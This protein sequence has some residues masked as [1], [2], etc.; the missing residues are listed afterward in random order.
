MKR[1]RAGAG[2]AAGAPAAAATAAA[3][4]LTLALPRGRILEDALPLFARAGID[5]G[6][7]EKARAGR[8]LIIAIPEHDLRVLIVRDTDVPAYVEGGAADMGIAGRDVLEDQDRDRRAAAASG[9]RIPH[10]TR[11]S[12]RDGSPVP[13]PWGASATRT[14]LAGA[15]AASAVRTT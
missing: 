6:A 12:A 2:K 5:L 4:T 9:G 1:R 13:G 8:R 15:P 14:G 3:E 10:L 7:A 11:R